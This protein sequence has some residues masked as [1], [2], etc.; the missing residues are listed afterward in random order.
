VLGTRGTFLLGAMAFGIIARC[1]RALDLPGLAAYALVVVVVA[2]AAALVG[3][4][5]SHGRVMAVA[6]ANSGLLLAYMLLT[7]P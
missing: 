3:R 6:Y 4:P 5:P 7:W 1:G 2:L